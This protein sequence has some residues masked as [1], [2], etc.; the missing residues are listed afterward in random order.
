MGDRFSATRAN[1]SDTTSVPRGSDR[2]SAYAAES[3]GGPVCS[4]GL[5]LAGQ[6]HTDG[7]RHRP[8]GG[9]GPG[10]YD[11]NHITGVN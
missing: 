10:Y 5:L 9:S 6:T 11:W 7:E 8:R 2:T 1:Q 4:G 3:G